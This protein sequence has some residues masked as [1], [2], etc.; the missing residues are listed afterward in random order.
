MPRRWGGQPYQGGPGFP[1]PA[2][3]VVYANPCPPGT[4]YS[5]E[6]ERCLRA[7]DPFASMG[8]VS[9]PSFV[10]PS[11]P[12]CGSAATSW[13]K[14]EVGET[15]CQQGHRYA[16][17]P[18]HKTQ[19]ALG[20]VSTHDGSLPLDACW[21]PKRVVARGGL[22]GFASLEVHPAPSG[23]PTVFERAIDF[24]TPD[25]VF[26]LALLYPIMAALPLPVVIAAYGATR[27]IKILR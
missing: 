5:H 6:A 1:T 10:R 18:V 21:C 25:S 16:A 20:N 9:V 27:F 23:E 13:C 15:T 7:V 8:R 26:A 4:W 14:C 19:I 17:C 3:Q 22:H 2:N 12:T 24:L 11:C